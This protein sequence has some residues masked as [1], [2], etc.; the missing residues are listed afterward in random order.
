MVPGR[1]FR[2]GATPRAFHGCFVL[3][4]ATF[5]FALPRTARAFERQWHV[6][7][8]AGYAQ[9]FGQSGSAG[10]G[11]GA[12]LAYG[13]SDM[14]NALL[15]VD[16][17]AHPGASSAVWSGAAGL[18]YT[19]DVTRAVPYAG[20]LVGVYAARGDF[21]KTAGMLQFALGFDYELDRNW[22]IGIQFRAPIAAVTPNVRTLFSV[23][24]DDTH[25][26]ATTF[27]RVEYL[28]GF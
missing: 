22:A 7:V 24:S 11:G 14:F 10:F 4:I 1:A 28:W 18:A 25:G 17:T 2:H 6:G 3:S 27:A 12:H 26:Y 13:L 5:V 9:L 16:A 23:T 19:F 8:D 20:L 21:D 15:E